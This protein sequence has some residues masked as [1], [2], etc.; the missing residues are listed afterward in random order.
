MTEIW[1]YNHFV[2]ICSYGNSRACL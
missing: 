1:W 2:I